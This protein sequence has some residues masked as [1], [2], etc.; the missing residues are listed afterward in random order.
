MAL[1]WTLLP[2]TV[3][4][5]SQEVIQ[6]LQLKETIRSE[7]AFVIREV[8]DLL[9]GNRDVKVCE[10]HRNQNR[11]SHFLANKGRSEGLS[12]FWPDNSCIAISQLVCDEA[13]SK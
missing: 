8:R 3:E 1:Q 5:D 10:I 4:S 12:H 9:S 7:L 2:I 13:N 11:I 6:L